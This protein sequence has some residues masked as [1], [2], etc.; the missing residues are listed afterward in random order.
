MIAV[1][2]CGR[3][4]MP[5]CDNRVPAS[6]VGDLETSFVSDAATA[7]GSIKRATV[8]STAKEHT[9]ER[10]EEMR[11]LQLGSRAEEPAGKDKDFVAT[12]T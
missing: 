6:M 5:L 12:N 2:V 1:V 4:L 9:A 3:Y 8:D 11:A 7:S 10:N